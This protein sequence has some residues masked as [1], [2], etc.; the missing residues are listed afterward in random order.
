MKWVI[1]GS[2]WPEINA[3]A[4]ALHT[5]G[6]L[7]IVKQIVGPEVNNLHFISPHRINKHFNII[8]SQFKYAFLILHL[9]LFINNDR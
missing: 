1:V 3:T 6:L 5:Y 4:S 2:R 9:F 8:M 7:N